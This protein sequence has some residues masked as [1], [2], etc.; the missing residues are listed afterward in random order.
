MS[1]M[2]KLTETG[3]YKQRNIQVEFPL[4]FN[5]DELPRPENLRIVD[6]NNEETVTQVDFPEYWDNKSLKQL[7]ITFQANVKSH[8]SALYHI[9]YGQ[10]IKRVVEA[11]NP[12]IINESKNFFEAYMGPCTYKVS[13]NTFNFIDQVDFKGQQFLKSNSKGPILKLKNG[14]E[15]TPDIDPEFSFGRVGLLKSDLIIKGTYNGGEYQFES[16]ITFVSRKTWVEIRHNLDH[17]DNVEA[18]IIESD[19]S[20]GDKPVDCAFG[21]RQDTSGLALGWSVVTSDNTVDTTVRDIWQNGRSRVRFEISSSGCQR[22]TFPPSELG[23]EIW[24]H[25]LIGGPDDN[26]NT[27]AGTMVSKMDLKFNSNI[28]ELQ[29]P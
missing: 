19:F 18:L 6:Q 28:G 26:I 24:Y 4:E 23:V 20:L 12:V 13:K 10:G 15:L 2:I 8:D 16:K 17:W 25:Y 14:K 7:L 3:G 11:E 29:C 27:P 1:V 5:K 9:E 21:S 22:V